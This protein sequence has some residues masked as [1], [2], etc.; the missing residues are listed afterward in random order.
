MANG[1]ITFEEVF[2]KAGIIPQWIERGIEQDRKE[3]IKN[4]LSKGYSMEMIHDLTGLDIETI[5]R[6]AGA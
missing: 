2:T 5:I 4:A 3:I 6:L 1:T